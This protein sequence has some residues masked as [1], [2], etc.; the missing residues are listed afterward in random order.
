MRSLAARILASVVGGYVLAAGASVAALALPMAVAQG[1]LA[2]M[3]LSFCVYA[4]AIVWAFA[5]RTVQAAWLGL[6][7]AAGV[8]LPALA[9]VWLKLGA[10]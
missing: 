8:Q 1:V 5:A 4:A 7:V 2:G 9:W 3:L 6:L 10:A